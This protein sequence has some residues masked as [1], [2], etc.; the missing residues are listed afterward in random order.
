MLG[1]VSGRSG[2]QDCEAKPL[3][4]YQIGNRA[5]AFV[6]RATRD[7]DAIDQVGYEL[8]ESRDAMDAYM[9][10]AEADG[11]EI[12]DACGYIWW[13]EDTPDVAE[14]IKGCGTGPN[15]DPN[16]YFEWTEDAFRIVGTVFEPEPATPET[17]SSPGRQRTSR[18]GP[19]RE[20]RATHRNVRA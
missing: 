12:S 19:S 6:S 15:G 7:D 16:A 1:I 3:T 13:F 18:V 20:H 11:F 14:G 17:R 8:F 10:T 2:V 9:L 4:E 5:I